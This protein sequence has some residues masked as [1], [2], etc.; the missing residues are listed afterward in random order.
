MGQNE[1]PRSNQPQRA[2]Y[3]DT[4]AIDKTE[5]TKEAFGQ[6]VQK[7]GYQEAAGWSDQTALAF[8]AKEPV[9]GVLWR[10]ADAYCK[11]TGKRLPSEA[12]WEK[13]ARGTDGRRYPWGNQ[14][15]PARANIA[16]HGYGGVM[17]V[18]SFTAGASPY[19][20]LDM[21]GNAAEWVADYF[22][23][24]YY[25][26]APAYNPQGPNRVMDHVLRGGSWDSPREHTQTFF[27]DSSHSAKPNMRVGFRCARSMVD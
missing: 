19:G 10:D 8:Q 20:A 22:D 1:G 7:S 6:F 12:E 11:W 23:F 14:W 26:S 21:A 16:E 9:V 13:A 2:V 25:T 18:G 17:P 5:V 27:R 4:F 15:E 3:L 24:D